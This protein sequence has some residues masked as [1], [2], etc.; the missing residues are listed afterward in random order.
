MINIKS[1]IAHPPAGET[2]KLSLQAEESVK[3]GLL[4]KVF[5][6]VFEGGWFN[7]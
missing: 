1:L 7:N 4:K 5:E 2:T 3:K 6:N